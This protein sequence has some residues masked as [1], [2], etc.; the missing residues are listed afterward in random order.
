MRA[1]N[2]TVTVQGKDSRGITVDTTALVAA[3]PL[4]EGAK[5][6]YTVALDSQPTGTVTVMVRGQSGDV[7]VNP[8]APYLHHQQLG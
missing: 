1:D 4:A 7:T 3:L 5:A 6:K 8:V 2:V